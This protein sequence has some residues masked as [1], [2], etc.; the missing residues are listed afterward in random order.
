MP[1]LCR[2]WRRRTPLPHLLRRGDFSHGA[3]IH[4]SMPT[5]SGVRNGQTATH[6]RSRQ[7]IVSA[8]RGM[9]W[10]REA[11]PGAAMHPAFSAPSSGVRPPLHECACLQ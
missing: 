10:Q 5:P 7:R 3:A 11:V 4:A 1:Q 2:T 9:W 6:L 8:V